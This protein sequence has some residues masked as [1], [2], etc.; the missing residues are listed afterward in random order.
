MVGKGELVWLVWGRP[1]LVPLAYGGK[2]A[3]VVAD[4]LEAGMIGI[5]Q[6]VGGS[7]DAPWV[8]AKQSDFVF[9]KIIHGL[10]ISPILVKVVCHIAKIFKLRFSRL[11]KS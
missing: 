6:G 2:E 5:N 3:E 11:P 7:V 9:L 8:G 10:G 1:L 4:Q